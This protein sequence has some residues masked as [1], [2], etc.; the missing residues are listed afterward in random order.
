MAVIKT[1]LKDSSSAY[2]RK[3]KKPMP[4]K[5]K[6]GLKT[7]KE[8]Q[9][10]KGEEKDTRTNIQKAND[11]KRGTT[12]FYKQGWHRSFI[13]TIMGRYGGIEAAAKALPEAK[14]LDMICKAAHEGVKG[15]VQTQD[16]TNQI[17]QINVQINYGNPNQR[18]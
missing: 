12:L 10:V 7:V 13:D 1:P 17:T 8:N 16:P 15:D 6:V 4:K 14:A 3:D 18:S 5:Q 11:A 2:T 9:E